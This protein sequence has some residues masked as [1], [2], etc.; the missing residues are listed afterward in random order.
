MDIH[1]SAGTFLKETREAAQLSCAQVAEAL[2][3]RT[4]VIQAIEKGE[5]KNIGVP[6]TFIRGYIKNYA[7]FLKLSE[8]PILPLL[9]T[10]YDV[11][12]N[13]MENSSL[14]QATASLSNAGFNWQK[15]L[16]ITIFF[17][18]V[19]IFLI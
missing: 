16:C 18:G 1:K 7:R 10:L 19:L 2:R 5:L 12:E 13:T 8:E 4:S 9:E 15:W 6:T 11:D 3:L 14:T 17:I